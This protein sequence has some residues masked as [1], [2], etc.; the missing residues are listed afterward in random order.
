MLQSH[1]W[2][3]SLPSASHPLVFMQSVTPPQWQDPVYILEFATIAVGSGPSKTAGMY[4]G[5][6]SVPS[7]LW[8]RIN[9]DE[10]EKVT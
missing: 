3:Y 8:E 4:F 10:L 2:I 6:R 9:I 1:S 5:S 7:Y